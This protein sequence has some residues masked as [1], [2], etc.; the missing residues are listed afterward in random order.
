MLRA[1]VEE[2]TELDRVRILPRLQRTGGGHAEPTTV[3]EG[4]SSLRI[5]LVKVGLTC[6]DDRHCQTFA[7]TKTL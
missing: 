6:K 7:D 4:K 2:T 3:N 1:A 5:S